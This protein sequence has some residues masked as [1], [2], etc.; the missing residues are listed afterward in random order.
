MRKTLFASLIACA[1][2]AGAV[3]WYLWPPSNLRVTNLSSS[4][5]TISSFASANRPLE[6]PL[7]VA[8]QHQ[9]KSNPPIPK[10]YSPLTDPPPVVTDEDIR[11][12]QNLLRGWLR[13]NIGG[14]PLSSVYE[15]L[16][17]KA[18]HGN[19]DSALELYR[20]LQFCRTVAPPS[21]QLERESIEIEL[22]E[23]LDKGLT[24][25]R[26]AH[27][28]CAGLT[29]VQ[30]HQEAHWLSLAADDGNLNAQATAGYLWSARKTQHSQQAETWLANATQQGNLS[31]LDF[32]VSRSAF[33]QH[34]LEKAYAYNA[35]IYLL[36]Q[37]PAVAEQ[38]YSMSQGLSPFQIQQAE[39][40]AREIYAAIVASRQSGKTN[41]AN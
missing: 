26:L 24:F 3:S 23:H 19:T 11:K 9:S 33:A 14:R 21:K 40:H 38:M 17:E 30:S 16:A 39:Q 7:S 1:I 15:S 41:H 32:M 18:E 36:T 10:L 8:K 12:Y 35:A 6:Q 34:N 37:S 5:D 13:P 22:D 20:G 28:Y 29:S 31:A 27:K 25:D 2:I 4:K